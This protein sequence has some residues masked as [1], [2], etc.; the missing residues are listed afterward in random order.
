MT[1]IIIDDNFINDYYEELNGDCDDFFEYNTNINLIINCEKII[2]K[3]YNSNN[4]INLK[5]NNS[6][7]LKEIEFN[8]N[9][10]HYNGDFSNINLNIS[11]CPNLNI[12]NFYFIVHNLSKLLTIINNLNLNFNNILFQF[13]HCILEYNRNFIKHIKLNQTK[14]YLIILLTLKS[15]IIYGDLSNNFIN[16]INP[17]KLTN[18]EKLELINYDNIIELPNNLINLKY[19]KIK[20]CKNI[21][22]L[23]NNLINLKE[24]YIN[25]EWYIK[26]IPDNLI[27]LEKLELIYC[28]NIKEIPNTFINL[29]YLN[30]KYCYNIKINPNNYLIIK[31]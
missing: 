1:N 20:N 22:K 13:I 16:L 10:N 21:K 11:N 9:N 26:K 31:N 15:L 6:K 8:N 2:I 25:E 18:L 3:F 7:Y 4:I 30:I 27:N 23:P 19:L 12:F 24:L 14:I 17:Y 5:I 28:D 29:K